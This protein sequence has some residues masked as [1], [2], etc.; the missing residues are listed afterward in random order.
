MSREY[1]PFVIRVD[2]QT[3]DAYPVTAEI[4]GASR[5][6]SIPAELPLLAQQEIQQAMRWLERGFMDRDYAKDFGSRLFHTLFPDAI[7]ERFR[8]ASEQVGPEK[9]LRIILTL[10]QALADLPWELMYDDEGGH[11]FLARSV[12]APLVRH[13][14]DLPLPHQLPEEEP[15]R[16]L[17]VTASPRG[18]PTVS[19]ER[20]VEKITRE[21]DRRRMSIREALGLVKRHLFRT[22]SPRGLL[23]RLRH[24][25]LVEIDVLPHAT[26]QNLQ[27]RMIEA[28]NANQGYH[29][30]HFIGH[31]QADES[32]GQL[33]LEDGEGGASPVQADEFA[34]MTAEPTVNLVVLN[35]C[36][37][38]SAA[39]LFRGVAQATLR[40]K[41]PAVIGMQVPVLDREAVEFAREFY[42]AWA[43][44]EPI[45]SALAYARRLIS[46]ETR[47]AAADWGIPVLYMGPVEGLALHMEAPPFHWPLPVRAMRWAIAAFLSLLSTVGLL[48]TI[49]DINRQ[50]RTEMPVIRCVFPYPMESRYNFNVVVT[51]FA[52]L[53]EDG[54]PV[55]SKDGRELA[56]FLFRR[57]ESNLNE[58][59]L[60]ESYEIRPP[61]HTCPIKGRTREERE[62]AAAALAERIG[63]HI[64][65]YGVVEQ[66]G[67]DPRFAP[68]FYIN[69]KGFEGAEGSEEITGQHEL[70]RPLRVTLPFDADQFQGVE[71]PALSARA[72]VLSLITVGLSYY[73]TDDYERA[74]DYFTKAEATEGWVRTAGKEVVYVLLGNASAGLTSKTQSTEYLTMTRE[75]YDEALEISPTYA[76][77]KIGQAGTLYTTALGDPA[78][79][80]WDTVDL[81]KLDEAAAAYEAALNLGDPPESANIETKVHFGLGQVYLVRAMVVGD[82]W[83]IQAEAEFEQVVEA[84][85]G[86]NT[87]ITNHAGHAHARLGAIARLRGATDA[88]VEHYTRATELASPYFQAYYYTRLGE[89]HAAAGQTDLAIE[90]YTE[91]IDRAELYGYEESVTEYNARLNELL[92]GE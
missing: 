1:E 83:L 48:L 23:Q 87:R 73:A 43:A 28:R 26:R 37:T 17:I 4:Q 29:V 77:A 44:G 30:V 40:R 59:D 6:G 35:A 51:E 80:S 85:E 60:K 84:Y 25:N 13:F 57:L 82:D 31:G 52:V 36:E 63:A 45:E 33:L 42:G 8:E 21:L 66:A 5:S 69:Y 12:T 39:S 92:A 49:P 91:A 74:L 79:P 61:A 71:N 34:E 19:S 50:L 41:V 54:S 64:I 14:T 55:R 20:E 15:L 90:A 10:P 58:L 32:G 22:H 72:E 24:R 18:Y 65:I 62:D 67:D 38:A 46:T 53:D 3:G 56:D 27:S 75:Y 9:G 68:E 70:G 89:V 16:V 47:G 88:A 81:E 7:R 78:V 86:G 76:R 11:G 2:E